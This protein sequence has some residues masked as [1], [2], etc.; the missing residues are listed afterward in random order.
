MGAL[1]RKLSKYL[2][3]A[4]A[5]A[6]MLL[7]LLVG[8]ARLLLPLV[9]D[10]QEDIRAWASQATGFD[11]QF[12]F[13]SASWP[14][15]GPEIRFLDVTIRSPDDLQ[16]IFVADSLNIGVSVV[17]L[18]RDRQVTVSRV[19][20]ENINVVLLQTDAREFLIQGRPLADFLPERDPDDPLELPEIDIQ[21]RDVGVAYRNLGRD[22]AIMDFRVDSID[23]RL[24]E[25]GVAADGEIQLPVRFGERATL[26]L[27]LPIEV[28]RGALTEAADDA[29]TDS[30]DWSMYVSG[31]ALK[32]AEL[33]EYGLDMPTPVAAMNGNLVIWAEFLGREPTGV[34]AELDFSDAEFRTEAANS[35]QYEAISGR[36]EWARAG[37]G[38]VLAGSDMNLRRVGLFAP[39][40]EFSVT[41]KSAG[42]DGRQLLASVDFMRL[43]D[44]YPIVRAFV[45]EDLRRDTLPASVNG[46]ISDFRLDARWISAAEREFDVEIRFED[47]GVVGL[48]AGEGLTGVSGTVVADEAGGRLQLDSEQ[49]ALTMPKLFAVPLAADALEGFL[50]WRATPDGVR[51]LSDNISVRIPIGEASSR[52]ELTLPSNGESPFLD[53]TATA[54][55]NSAPG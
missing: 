53:L 13:I 34:T 19:G 51:V 47:I 10:Y 12:E 55:V 6:V 44:W 3:Y 14:I 29:P 31:E 15:A 25:T 37:G 50:V 32:M 26:S 39:R 22:D 46:D 42:G 2:A 8:V 52:F 33:L 7:A 43:E 16:P 23:L 17:R 28:L 5:A 1:I 4:A 24:R 20:I 11:V 18:L 9:P 48:P 27:D 35:D 49:A 40:T 45:S 21:L 36:V 30:V 41:S 38:W 54:Q